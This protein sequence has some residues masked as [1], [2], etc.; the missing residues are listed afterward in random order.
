VIL[1]EWICYDHFVMSRQCV[2]VNWT[3][4]DVMFNANWILRVK[5]EVFWRN[6]FYRV[7]LIKQ[8]T[9]LTSL[10]QH[11]GEWLQSLSSNAFVIDI[12]RQL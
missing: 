9:Q 7:S 10:A 1:L 2:W 11:S 8:S 12:C 3:F 5:E 4:Y 6:Y